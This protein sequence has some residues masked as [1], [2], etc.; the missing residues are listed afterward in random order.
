MSVVF[1]PSSF[2]AVV[3]LYSIFHLPREL[4]SDLF[5][6]V[7]HWLKPGGYLLCTLSYRSEAG[8]TEDDFFRATMYWSNYGLT[9]FVVILTEVGFTVLTTS[10]TGS[11]HE[12]THQET[13][14]DHPLVLVQK[15]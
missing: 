5:R 13:L 7:H 15:Q 4:H 8:Y 12:K 6:R 2:D 9:E 1:P 3:A 11:G 14:E 10:T